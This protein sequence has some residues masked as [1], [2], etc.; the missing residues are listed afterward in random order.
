MMS[1]EQINNCWWNRRQGRQAGWS[2][3]RGRSFVFGR[4]GEEVLALAEALMF[5]DCTGVS[6]VLLRRPMPVFVLIAAW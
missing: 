4:G 5:R 3:K 2:L 6:S 1:Q